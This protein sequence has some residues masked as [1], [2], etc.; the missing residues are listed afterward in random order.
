MERIFWNIVLVERLALVFAD[1]KKNLT[2]RIRTIDLGI[3]IEDIYSPPLYQL[4][5]GEFVGNETTAV[6]SR[7]VF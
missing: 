5:Y 6:L 2:G 4:S 1:G 3:T 7:F